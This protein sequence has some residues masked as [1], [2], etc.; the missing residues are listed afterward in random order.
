MSGA[1]QTANEK[2]N[3][4]EVAVEAIERA[5]V[6]VLPLASEKTF[7]VESKK[8]I[9]VA[10]VHHEIDIFVTID[11]GLGYKS[12]F[13]FECKNWA[14]AVGKNEIII[15]SEKIKAIGAQHGFVVAK[16]FT[17]DAEAQAELDRRVTLLIAKEH[18]AL[19][20]PMPL[21]L[22][23]IAQEMRHIDVH[24]NMRG[25]SGTTEKKI[26]PACANAVS[27]GNA[28]DLAEYVKKWAEDEAARKINSFSSHHKPDAVYDLSF[29]STRDFSWGEFVL[30]DI[31]IERAKISVKL[32]VRVMHPSIVSHFEIESRGRFLRLTPIN[33][34]GSDLTVGMVALDPP[35]KT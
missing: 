20:T 31:D 28:L 2:G 26:D 35:R 13:I 19:A 25:G 10:G 1:K 8:I 16:S 4:L 9:N 17:A 3:A 18:D 30:D 22:H 11:L 33:I 6:G 21:D 7:I 34:S 5:I 24:F 14:D 23:V 32:D 29:E 12:I 15:F 27:Q